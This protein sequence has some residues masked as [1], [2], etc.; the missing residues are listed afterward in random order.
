MIP[1]E[2]NYTLRLSGFCE[3]SRSM[4]VSTCPTSVYQ[5]DP[6]CGQF[7]PS[8]QW[9]AW[10]AEACQFLPVPPLYI[11]MT[12]PVV[13]YNS[14]LSGFRVDSGGMSVSKFSLKSPTCVY[15]YTRI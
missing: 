1:P 4:S 8:S 3:D 5:Y 13:N 9:F 10:I 15:R 6:T 12:P 11:N 2:V 14:R 7:H